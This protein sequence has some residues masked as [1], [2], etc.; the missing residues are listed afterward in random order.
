MMIDGIP[1]RPLYFYQKDIIVW[2]FPAEI[3]E[4]GMTVPDFESFGDGLTAPTFIVPVDRTFFFPIFLTL[5][6]NRVG[7]IVVG[8]RSWEM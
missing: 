5:E 7:K 3:P 1:N 4:N 8:C 6:N 2:D